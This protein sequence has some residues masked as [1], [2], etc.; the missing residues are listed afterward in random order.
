[1]KRKS[2]RNLQHSTVS[3]PSFHTTVEVGVENVHFADSKNNPL[4]V[5]AGLPHV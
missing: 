2:E 4:G 1:M 3:L 5:L